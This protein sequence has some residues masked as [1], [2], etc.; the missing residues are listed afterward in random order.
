MRGTKP[1]QEF[2]GEFTELTPMRDKTYLK[3]KWAL[4]TMQSPHVRIKNNNMVENN[5]TD[6]EAHEHK[7]RH[8]P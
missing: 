2:V 8:K 7:R 3:T 5:Y 4:P 1:Y 6:E